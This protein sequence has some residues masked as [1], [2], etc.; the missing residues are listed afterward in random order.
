M[1]NKKSTPFSDLLPFSKE[2]MDIFDTEAS[3]QDWSLQ[4]PSNAIQPFQIYHLSQNNPSKR[5]PEL[6]KW[7]S[8]LKSS[9]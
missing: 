5:N 7:R 3:V 1:E 6:Q 2:H 8:H 9:M 4:C